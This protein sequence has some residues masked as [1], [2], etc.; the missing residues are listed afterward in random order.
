VPYL[1]ER[2]KNLPATIKE[3]QQF[4][5]IGKEKHKAR[6]AAIEA[7]TDI[8]EA[9]DRKEELLDITINELIETWIAHAKL[10]E[11][12]GPGHRGGDRKSKEYKNQLTDMSVDFNDTDKYRARA[13]YDALI[14]DVL[15]GCILHMEQ[16]RKPPAYY[17]PYNQI[18]ALKRKQNKIEIPL[19]PGK[20]PVIMVDPP[21]PIGSMILDDKWKQDVDYDKYVPLPLDE[22]KKLNVAELATDDCSLFLWTTHTFL[23]KAFEVLKTWNFKFHVCLTW[24][25]HGGFTHC[26]FHRNT[27]LCLYAYRGKININP[28]GEAIPLLID[29]PK[30]EHS[31]KPELLY[32]LIEKKIPSP[33]INLFAREIREGWDVW[34]NEI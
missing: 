22:I 33:R 16:Q 25:K 27:E 15:E 24:Y 18:C 19:P 3:L 29:E 28:G 34:G 10:G 5:K 20:Y 2:Y 21:W 9:K 8:K 4:V 13:F 1:V 6:M 17:K 11:L 32:Q 14:S 26:G 30:R 7:I 23:E 12:L 31:R